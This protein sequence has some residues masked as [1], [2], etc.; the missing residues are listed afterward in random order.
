[1]QVDWQ[2]QPLERVSEAPNRGGFVQEEH[3]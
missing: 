3:G 2:D 1:V